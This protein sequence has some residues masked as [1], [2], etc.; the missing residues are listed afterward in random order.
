MKV[1]GPGQWLALQNHITRM[2]STSRGWRM[3]D[4]TGC[5]Y[6]QEDFPSGLKTW[7]VPTSG[8]TDAKRTPWPPKVKPEPRRIRVAS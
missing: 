5:T 2:W 7:D 6:K 8:N 4:S 3:E 1:L